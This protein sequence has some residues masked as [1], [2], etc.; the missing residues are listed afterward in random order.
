MITYRWLRPL[1]RNLEDND[2]ILSRY[3]SGLGEEIGD[4]LIVCGRSVGLLDL[5]GTISGVAHN[6][7]DNLELGGREGAEMMVYVL[8]NAVV[9]VVEGAKRVSLN[10]L[11]EDID[12]DTAM[13]TVGCV[14]LILSM[15]GYIAI[16]IHTVCYQAYR[17]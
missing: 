13:I 4:N 15:V 12:G 2:D 1:I 14:L 3:G 16:C 17:A 9:A 7:A 5:V 10:V 11:E 6:A 8:L